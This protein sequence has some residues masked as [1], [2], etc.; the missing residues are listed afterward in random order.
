MVRISDRPDM[1][2]AVYR[3]RKAKNVFNTIMNFDGFYQT[4]RLIFSILNVFLIIFYFRGCHY[5]DFLWALSAMDCTAAII[6][7]RTTVLI[8]VSM[9]QKYV[10]S[11]RC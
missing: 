7:T 5:L 1:T 3:R 9:T 4:Y 6:K 2:S 10:I 8:N 11:M